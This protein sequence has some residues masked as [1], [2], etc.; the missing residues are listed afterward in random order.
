MRDIRHISIVVLSEKMKR[1]LLNDM[2]DFLDLEAQRWYLSYGIPYRRGYLLYGPPGT[3]KSSL[4]LSI[5]GH[6]ELDIY[7]LSLSSIDEGC[8]KT[9]FA[10][11]PRRC[12]ILLEDIDAAS[13]SRSRDTEMKDFC[14]TVTGSPPQKNK[15][16]QGVVSLSA[17][18]NVI[19]GVAS[20]EGQVLIM[21]T[22]Y[23][24]RLDE[25]LIRPSRADRKVEFRLADEEMITQLFY[26][27]FKHSE[28]DVAHPRKLQSNALVEE[29]KTVERLPKEL[30]VKV[31]KLEF[32]PAEI[33]SFLLEYKQPP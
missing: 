8:L 18:L 28:G 14:Q 17:L 10:E 30:A 26:V 27:V 11:L 22:N 7:I 9:L 6:F 33:L 19:D 31:P 15:A 24:E 23:I 1:H 16:T 25:A 20:Q 21:T 3:G 32:S 4:S 29:D 2:R 12:V 5:A 13:L